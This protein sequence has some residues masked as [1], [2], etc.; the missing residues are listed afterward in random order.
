MEIQLIKLVHASTKKV[1][2]VKRSY[3]K[4]NPTTFLKLERVQGIT[5][6]ERERAEH[7]IDPLEFEAHKQEWEKNNVGLMF[8]QRQLDQKLHETHQKLEKTQVEE[9][10]VK[11][12]LKV[13]QQNF[14]IVDGTFTR[15]VEEM[16]NATI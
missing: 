15:V 9:K 16:K 7:C 5:L 8:T 10:E 14:M 2:D 13:L 6:Y 12:T 4:N 3:K 11:Q 1:R